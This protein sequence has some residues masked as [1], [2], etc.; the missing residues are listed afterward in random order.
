MIIKS[1]NQFNNKTK[2]NKDD[3]SINQSIKVN[4]Y[5]GFAILNWTNAQRKKIAENLNFYVE[6]IIILNNRYHSFISWLFP[7]YTVCLRSGNQLPSQ[8]KWMNEL[9]VN[10][11]LLNRFLL[12]VLFSSVEFW[13]SK[14]LNH[15]NGY[16]LS[17]NFMH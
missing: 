3:S 16:I 1:I 6:M 7:V 4:E 9:L 15:S 11:L 14:Q 5:F 13:I 8:H 17:L 10:S 12:F 2:K